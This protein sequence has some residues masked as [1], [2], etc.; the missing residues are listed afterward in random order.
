[1]NYEAPLYLILSVFSNFP[2]PHFQIPPQRRALLVS[3][4][5]N[6]SHKYNLFVPAQ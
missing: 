6:N 3:F 5:S 4:L 2:L 1:M